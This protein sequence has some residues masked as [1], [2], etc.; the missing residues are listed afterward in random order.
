MSETQVDATN[1]KSRTMTFG[2]VLMGLTTL[3]SSW[4][5]FQSSLWD[6]VQTFHL[7]D[8]ADFSRQANEKASLA[9]QQRTLD[10]SLFVEYA[11]DLADGK[12]HLAEFFLDR[13]RPELRDAIKAWTATQPVKNPNA[14]P[15]PF[16]M[17]QYHV[18]ADDESADF[19]SRA[20]ASHDLAQ[21]ANMTSDSY[22]LLTVLFA[23]GLFL[24]GLVST[25]DEKRARLVT[26]LM[27][28]VISIIATVALLRL[29]IARLG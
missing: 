11:R 2:L 8:S 14:P 6:G 5:G 1:W 25:I 28:A 23:T 10:A 22:T 26:L 7:M 13:T 27:G 29:P 24:A 20:Q 3:G 4:C 19:S 16:L 21:K 9:T 15:T 18:K 17:P 12:T